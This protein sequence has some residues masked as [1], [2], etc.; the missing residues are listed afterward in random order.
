MDEKHRSKF[1]LKISVLQS[2]NE[3]Y[4]HHFLV[5][6]LASTYLCDPKNSY[7]LLATSCKTGSRL[8]DG[9]TVYF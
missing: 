4:F 6:H 7:K 2:Y 9:S 5:I 3:N 1:L 8:R